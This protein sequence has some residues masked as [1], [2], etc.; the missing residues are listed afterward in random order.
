MNRASTPP[1]VKR[2]ILLLLG[3]YCPAHHRGIA[4]YA[5]DAGWS[6]DNL[7]AQGGLTP[8]WWSG[9]GMITLITHPKDYAAFRLFPPR[10]LVDLSKGWMTKVMPP[11][12]RRAGRGRPRVLCDSAGIGRLAAEHFLERGFRHLAFFN[13]G[14][15]WME[16]DSLPAFRETVSAA[17]AQVH[18]IPYHRHFDRTLPR[19]T[20]RE[21]AAQ[22]WL[23]ETLRRLPKPLGVY[24]AAD[25]LAFT[26][27]RACGD[28]GV[29]VPEEVAVLGCNNDSLICDFAPV[30]LS[31][32][33]SDLEAQGY[34]AAKL[35]DRL[36]DGKPPPREPII[37]PPRGVVT[38]QSTNI[39]A[40]PHVQVA[41]ALRFIWE[42]YRERIQTPD[43]AAASGMSRRG[44]E[45]AFRQ[46]LHRSINGEI[47][48][49]RLEHVRDLL[50]KTD[51]KVY[52]AA[53]EAGFRDLPN[54]YQLF[55]R[56]TGVRP[57]AFRRQ[58]RAE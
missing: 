47:N 22:R 19:P 28:A 38:R 43:V 55:L 20:A 57:G 21:H 45:H 50:A 49:R 23:M 8:V 7:Y 35:L 16:I 58:H 15:Y 54:F 2:Q 36:M 39:L 48:R 30:P 24:A 5:R 31:S 33:D 56:E 29:S 34:E 44:L 12:V 51:L 26:V 53:H 3:V 9:D 40:V 37:I 17:G 14:N 6:L 10:P 25:D 18:E 4:R 32:V 11:S 1:R 42:H 27:L 13:F 52:Q 41:R 46:H